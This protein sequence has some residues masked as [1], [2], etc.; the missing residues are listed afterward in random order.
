MEV[1]IKRLLH[2]LVKIPGVLAPC[3][4]WKCVPT[5]ISCCVDV[6]KVPGC[7]LLRQ[8][9][10]QLWSQIL[11]QGLVSH[12]LTAFLSVFNLFLTQ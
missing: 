5:A 7:H 8:M 6:S 1:A 10:S 12:E 11:P 9:S 4:A 3:C 2:L